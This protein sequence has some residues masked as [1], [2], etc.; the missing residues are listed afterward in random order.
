MA[1]IERA[2]RI[3]DAHM[4][5]RMRYGMGG[6]EDLVARLGSRDMHLH[7]A[8][9]SIIE[10]RKC[11]ETLVK[12]GRWKPPRTTGPDYWLRKAAY[13]RRQAISATY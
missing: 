10:A 5:P 13:N 11:R 8:A 2:R 6:L 7:H 12:Q 4:A 3:A 1:T 9:I